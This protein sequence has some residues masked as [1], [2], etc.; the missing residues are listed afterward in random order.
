MHEVSKAFNGLD[1]SN[2][3]ID[4]RICT[5]YNAK[6]STEA[7]TEVAG[8]CGGIKN[9][10]SGNTNFKQLSHMFEGVG[11]D[12]T[13]KLYYTDTKNNNMREHTSATISKDISTN[14]S[15][16]QKGIVSSAFAKAHEGAEIVA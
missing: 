7:A 9:G 10:A 6:N 1:P 11:S 8:K 16:D 15:K 13:D 12:G 4:K 3:A 5:A 14:L 2:D